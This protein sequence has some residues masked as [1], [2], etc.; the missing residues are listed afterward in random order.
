M[1]Q[2]TQ[3]TGREALISAMRKEARQHVLEY[4]LTAEDIEEA[5]GTIMRDVESFQGVD[6]LFGQ[7]EKLEATK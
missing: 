1:Q 6:G 4:D 5:A 3:S 7:A 2:Q